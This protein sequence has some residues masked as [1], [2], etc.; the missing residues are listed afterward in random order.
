MG[1]K[2]ARVRNWEKIRGK[3]CLLDMRGHQDACTYNSGGGMHK[4]CIKSIQLIFL[5]GE[6][7]PHELSPL[8]VDLLIGDAS[9]E[10]RVCIFKGVAHRRSNMQWVAPYIHENTG[11][12]N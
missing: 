3:L 4:T 6:R 11:S 12:T 2:I 8:A 10:K 5:L 7:E 1:S 9:L